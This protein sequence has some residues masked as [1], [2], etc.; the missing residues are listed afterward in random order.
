MASCVLWQGQKALLQAV[1]RLLAQPATE[2]CLLALVV[3]AGEPELSLVVDAAI[4]AM[5]RHP[6][7]LAFDGRESSRL[8]YRLRAGGPGIALSIWFSCLPD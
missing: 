8:N 3:R 7:Y 2:S 1:D 4:R 5:P 6:A